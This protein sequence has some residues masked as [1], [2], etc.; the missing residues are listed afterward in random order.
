[1]LD[2]R[3]RFDEIFD[4]ELSQNSPCIPLA[5]NHKSHCYCLLYLFKQVHLSLVILLTGLYHDWYLQVQRHFLSAEGAAGPC[6]L[7]S[8]PG[9]S[10]EG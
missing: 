8:V 2:F 6:R 1:M 10:Q 5:S 9:M 7:C 4:D 3:R